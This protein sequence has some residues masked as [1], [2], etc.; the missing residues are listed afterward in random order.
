MKILQN[1]NDRTILI[2]SETNFGTDLGWEENFQEFENETLK[3]IINPTENFETVRYIHSGYTGMEGVYQHDIW[4][5]FYFM[6]PLGTYAGGLNYEHIGLSSEDNAKLLRSNNNS[7]FRLEFYKIPEGENP[8]SNN[9]KL[10][11]SRNLPIPLGEQVDYTPI[12][13]KIYVPVFVGSNYR[14]KENMYLFWFQDDTVLEGTTLSGNTFYMS[15][16]FYNTID[17]SY[18]AFLNKPL[19]VSRIVNEETDIY[20][21]VII[22][23][24]NYSYVVYTGITEDHRGGESSE[25]TPLRWYE[26]G[27]V[28]IPP[29]PSMTP[30]PSPSPIPLVG[31][32]TLAPSYGLTFTELTDYAEYPIEWPHTIED[33]PTPFTFP[34]TSTQTKSF[35]GFGI[36]SA[37][38]FR[39]VLGGS[40]TTSGLCIVIYM[41]FGNGEVIVSNSYG[42][43]LT[44][45]DSI[46]LPTIW[47]PLVVPNQMRMTINTGCSVLGRFVLDESRVGYRITSVT[48]NVGNIPTFDFPINSGGYEAKNFTT[49]IPAQTLTVTI[50]GGDIRSCCLK[51]FSHPTPITVPILGAGTYNIAMPEVDP[52]NG[53]GNIILSVTDSGC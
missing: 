37:Y 29:T 30:T 25:G 41:D 45:G 50:A 53:N 8:N 27:P 7:F 24:S 46:I 47:P 44:I 33:Y 16:K 13:Q 11:F 2:N 5:E 49:T 1:N 19:P 23:R 3:E 17:G 12:N 9:R 38:S 35:D 18:I 39:F 40:I 15:S 31:S 10:V 22:D 36:L 51:V 20:R 34:V 43:T 6:N 26:N 4:H 52:V 42:T 28:I 14:N 32:I 21:K 48:G